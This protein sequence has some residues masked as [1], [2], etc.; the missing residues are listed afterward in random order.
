MD[1][2]SAQ[3][4]ADQSE[5]PRKRA[6]VD[7]LIDCAVRADLTLACD[8][9]DVAVHSQLLVVA[10]PVLAEAISLLEPDCHELRLEGERRVV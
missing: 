6:R 9:G 10:S 7:D 5:R 2:A 3:A 8:D 4:G 1:A